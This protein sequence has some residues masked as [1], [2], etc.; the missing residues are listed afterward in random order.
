MRSLI[1]S[2]LCG[3]ILKDQALIG[4]GR[5]LLPLWSSQTII[6]LLCSSTAILEPFQVIK[7]RNKVLAYP[8]LG[9]LSQ[10]GKILCL[11]Q[12]NGM[13][14]KRVFPSPNLLFW[15]EEVRVRLVF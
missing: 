3:F 9:V 14:G 10:E 7:W 13:R 6:H 15:G 5:L 8:F 4:I 2:N 1:S 11:L 12:E